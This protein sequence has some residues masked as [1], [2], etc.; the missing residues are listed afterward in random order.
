VSFP[1]PA[2]SS[3]PG[4]CAHDL[5]QLGPKLD[6]SCNSCVQNIC[7]KDPYCCNGGY[8]S[9]YSFQPEWDARCIAEV[10]TYCPGS[11]CAP[12]A[13]LP[14]ISP[15]KKSAPLPMEAGVHYAIRLTYD[16]SSS[17]KTIR[18]LWASP[19]QGKQAVPQYALLPPGPPN[20]AG[21][22]LN[23]TFFATKSDNGMVKADG[24]RLRCD[25]GPFAD[26][27]DRPARFAAG[28]RPGGACR[29]LVWQ[30]VAPVGHP[31]AVRRGSLRQRRRERTDHRHRR[32]QLGRGADHRR[33]RRRRD[34]A[35]W[36]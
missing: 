11:Q 21:S 16:N 28:R 6:A 19:R 15:Q 9:Y 33:H 30:A 7:D 31:S 3:A 8:L 32:D 2:A 36:S 23:V 12:P 5:C 27:D 25:R 22:G 24:D 13:P 14:P 1:P 17:D 35:G 34:R 29:R 10:A 20:N 26:A 18:L 4:G